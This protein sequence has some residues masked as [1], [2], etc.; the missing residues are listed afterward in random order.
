MKE[1]ATLLRTS[2]LKPHSQ[3]QFRI[4]PRTPFCSRARQTNTLKYIPLSS[5]GNHRKSSG[6]S[7]GRKDKKDRWPI[8]IRFIK[9]AFICLL[10]FAF[11]IILF[12][13]P[14]VRTRLDQEKFLKKNKNVFLL[15][16]NHKITLH[17]QG[18][19]VI[20]ESILHHTCFKNH[21]DKKDLYVVKSKTSHF[22]NFKQ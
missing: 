12:V 19:I 8:T 22:S 21:H 16:N 3:I 2:E 18:K 17:I 5:F 1:Y 13:N 15:F 11:H 14:V 4:I 9:L 6:Y 10:A 20:F 7:S